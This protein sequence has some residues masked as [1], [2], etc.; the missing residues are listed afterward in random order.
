[1]IISTPH[2][3][4]FH[5][6]FS[7][8]SI[9]ALFRRLSFYA[10]FLRLISFFIFCY[11]ICL[12]YYLEKLCWIFAWNIKELEHLA[13]SLILLRN[14]LY[15]F[16][17]YLLLVNNYNSTESIES[18][19]K[20]ERPIITGIKYNRTCVV[21]ITFYIFSSSNSSLITE[22]FSVIIFYTI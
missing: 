6:L 1:M 14:I 22:L 7:G 21:I 4:F 9:F 17:R 13:I 20:L 3:L 8:V 2:F 18:F 5:L 16:I 11:N 12:I 15:F 10:I 19:C